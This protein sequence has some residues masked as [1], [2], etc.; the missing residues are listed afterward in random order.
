MIGYLS[1]SMGAAQCIK[2]GPRALRET[3]GVTSMEEV[4]QRLLWGYSLEQLR[5]L[6]LQTLIR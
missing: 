1:W 3:Y 4:F 5:V 6:S 2:D